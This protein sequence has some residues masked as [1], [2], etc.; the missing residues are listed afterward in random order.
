MGLERGICLWEIRYSSHWGKNLETIIN[1]LH[2]IVKKKD[3]KKKYGV[4]YGKDC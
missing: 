3:I 2:I 1:K 4:K